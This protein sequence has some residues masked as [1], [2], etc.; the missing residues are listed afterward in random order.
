MRQL[1]ED[2]LASL[3]G[4]DCGLCGAPTCRELARDVSVGDASKN[5]CVFLSERRLQ[6]LRRVYLRSTA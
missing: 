4:L 6:D 3:P 2:A 1:A 5:D